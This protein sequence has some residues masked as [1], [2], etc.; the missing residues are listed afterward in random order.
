MARTC[1][2]C[3]TLMVDNG[4]MV[5]TDGTCL[6]IRI[7]KEGKIFKKNIG[8]PCVAVCPKCGELSIYTDN[9]EA[10]KDQLP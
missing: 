8:I 4:T 7:K 9:I 5:A 3:G 2:R 6:V 10:L 1:I